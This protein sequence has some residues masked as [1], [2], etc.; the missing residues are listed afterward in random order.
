MPDLLSYVFIQR[1][2]S[3]KSMKKSI[4]SKEK[5]NKDRRERR[6]RRANFK[7]LHGDF[8]NKLVNGQLFKNKGYELAISA[9]ELNVAQLFNLLQDGGYKFSKPPGPRSKTKGK[10]DLVNQLIAEVKFAASLHENGVI[11]NLRDFGFEINMT[12]QRKRGNQQAHPFYKK[13]ISLEEKPLRS[14]DWHNQHCKQ[15]WWNNVTKVAHESLDEFTKEF[16]E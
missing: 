16:N 13:P 10:F 12:E 5:A 8:A 2:C 15:C 9:G 7:D 3:A 4:M 6:I 11:Q 1:Y 14:V